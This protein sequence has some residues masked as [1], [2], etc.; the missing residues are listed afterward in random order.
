MNDMS[1]GL[2]VFGWAVLA[3]GVLWGIFLAF[4]GGGP[5]ALLWCAFL[6]GI[7]CGVL[8]G[9]SEIIKLLAQQVDSSHRMEEKLNQLSP[10]EDTAPKAPQFCH[11]CGTQLPPGGKTC[12]TC[13]HVNE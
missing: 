8:L 4:S 1:L 2:R 13:H 11:R 10:S 9:L 5:M 3:F 7:A 6:A 12:P